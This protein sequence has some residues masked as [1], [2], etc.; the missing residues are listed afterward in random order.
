MIIITKKLAQKSNFILNFIRPCTTKAN[1]PNL[2]EAFAITLKDI[3]SPQEHAKI[4]KTL[5]ESSP[6]E[7]S[8]FKISNMRVRSIC[9][10]KNTKGSFKSLSEVLEVEGF[11]TKMLEQI[12]KNIACNNIVKHITKKRSPLAKSFLLPEMDFE[13]STSLQSAVAIHI[14]PTGI[15]WARLTKTGNTITNWKC[16]SFCS[17]PTKMLPSDTFNLAVNLLEVTPS[18]DAYIIEAP[19][20]L[21]PQSQTKQGIVSAHNHQVELISMLLALLNTSAKHNNGLEK[22]LENK[23]FFL[24]SKIAARLFSTL[25]GYEKVSAISVITGIVNK[26]SKVIDSLP[27][28]PIDFDPKLNLA[29]SNRSSFDK[30]LLAQALMLVASFMDLCIHRNSKCIE[31]LKPKRHKKDNFAAVQE[32]G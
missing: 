6:E 13:L 9:E 1:R 32:L 23:V 17:L 19:P 20:T 2:Q 8:R 5:N 4:L 11:G 14:E 24:R 3:F 12:C 21:G 25:I 31:A 7:L 18:A 22:S 15:G 29:F 28:T 26:D 27:C 30:E 10:W 16:Q